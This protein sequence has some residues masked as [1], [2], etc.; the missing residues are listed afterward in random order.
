MYQ[1]GKQIV[2]E[3]D[4]VCSKTCLV[5]LLIRSIFHGKNCTSASARVQ[6]FERKVEQINNGSNKTCFALIAHLLSIR[7][8]TS[9]KML[10]NN[11]FKAQTLTNPTGNFRFQIL[12]SRA[13][14]MSCYFS[15]SVRS[16][17]SSCVVKSIVVIKISTHSGAHEDDYVSENISYCH[18]QVPMHS[19]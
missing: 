16:I 1:L 9:W 13:L 7:A 14:N 2:V 19:C 15:Q 17:E 11:K 18:T 12:A 3:A 10:M 6:F 4:C 5:G 8:I